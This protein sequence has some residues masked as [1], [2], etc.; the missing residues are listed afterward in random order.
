TVAFLTTSSYPPPEP[1][2]SS[3]HPGHFFARGEGSPGAR[4][5]GGGSGSGAQGSGEEFRVWRAEFRLEPAAAKR[6]E[7][8]SV[9][10]QVF[11]IGNWQLDPHRTLGSACPFQYPLS[12][13]PSPLKSS[14]CSSFIVSAWPSQKAMA[15]LPPLRSA[16]RE[17]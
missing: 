10:A 12:G 13:V 9:G 14:S 16:G 15:I 8:R 3:P 1:W 2:M 17:R 4:G 11:T 5:Q 6:R 7:L